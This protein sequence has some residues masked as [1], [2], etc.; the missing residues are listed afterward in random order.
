MLHLMQFTHVWRCGGKPPVVR[1]I[2]APTQS[3]HTTTQRVEGVILEKS[4][5][6]FFLKCGKVRFN[7]QKEAQ[8]LLEVNP[9]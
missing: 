1:P 8:K 7:P 2:S 3:K 6:I 4:T 9:T 5:L